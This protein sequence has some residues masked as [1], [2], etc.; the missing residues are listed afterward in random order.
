M[1]DEQTIDGGLTALAG[2]LYQTIGVL[3]MKAGAYQLDNLAGSADLEAIL[4][5]VKQSE[6]RYEYLDQD[7]A[8]R[9]ELG[10][11][12][13]DNF[14]LVQFK[15][16]RQIPVPKITPKELTKIIS[17]LREST[18]RARQ[19]GQQ[20]GGYVL[21]SNR[22]LG[23]KAR[24]MQQEAQIAKSSQ[25][26][27]GVLRQ[28]RVLPPISKATW[29]EKLKQFART[30]G[31]V[32]SDIR[33]GIDERIGSII[34][35]TVEQGSPSI[36]KDDLIWAFTG[37][38]NT[39]QLTPARVAEQSR[40]Q[41]DTFF[42][43]HHLRQKRILVRRKVLDAISQLSSE[44]AVVIVYGFGG[45]GKTV[46]LW[47]WT[48]EFL[49]SSVPHQ[50]GMYTAILAAEDVRPDFL[51]HLLCDWADLPYHHDW[52]AESMPEHILERLRVASPGGKHPI[53]YLSVDGIDEEQSINDITHR[54]IKQT[55]GW[56]WKE[57]LEVRRSGRLPRATII[58]TCRDE[59]EIANRWLYLNS[60]FGD[61]DVHLPSVE[62]KD[63]TDGE[64]M[65]AARL[66]LSG[67]LSSRIER[68]LLLEKSDYST[69]MEESD[70]PLLQKTDPFLHSVDQQILKA[71]HHPALWRCFLTLDGPSIQSLVLSGDP[72][73]LQQLAKIYVYWFCSK[74][75]MR[76]HSLKSNELEAVLTSIARQCR[77]DKHID[78]ERRSW[79]D[80]ACSTRLI[81]DVGAERLYNEAISAGL[82]EKIDRDT[83][84]WRHRF[85]D[86]YLLSISSS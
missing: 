36:T 41:L 55:L 48:E 46:S 84:H 2:Y 6:L 32:D 43:R 80:S 83:W 5:L 42:S 9:R 73:M 39:R 1:S 66:G 74:A 11:D 75:E 82:I 4:L 10:I 68:T 37:F 69:F 85:I 45:N 29:E 17:R 51:T 3:G 61:D 59:R 40:L 30:Y 56:F 53:L 27:D 21:I 67:E 25:Q 81:T 16:S 18:Q 15:F 24:E 70:V 54:A 14:V 49:A 26:V 47:H 23:P 34:R 58:L 20:I 77:V 79:I 33:K 7:A 78:H 71:L 8:I 19:L 76:G 57:E 65:Q 35:Q 63:F 72:S 52:R 62:V 86:E 22:E 38:R 64:L 13:R 28:L 50:K 31:C 60:P 12:D 44:H